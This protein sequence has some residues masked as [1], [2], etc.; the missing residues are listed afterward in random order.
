MYDNSIFGFQGNYT[1]FAFKPYTEG[2]GKDG[3]VRVGRMGST[4]GKVL[5]TCKNFF[6]KVGEFHEDDDKNLTEIKEKDAST[7]TEVDKTFFENIPKYV[8]IKSIEWASHNKPVDEPHCGYIG[9]KCASQQGKTEYAAAVLGGMLIFSL[10]FTF[11][12]AIS[13][14]STK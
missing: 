12:I 10:F 4:A 11:N 13:V 7:S 14:F 6:V 8:R 5:W 9:E 1:A 2:N 3:Y